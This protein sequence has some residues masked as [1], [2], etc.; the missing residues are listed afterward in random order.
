LDKAQTRPFVVEVVQ[1]PAE[2]LAPGLG[3]ITQVVAVTQHLEQM[4]D[5]LVLHT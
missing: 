5:G 4:L 2:P 3:Q 1:E